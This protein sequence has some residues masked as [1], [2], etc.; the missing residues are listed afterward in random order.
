MLRRDFL[1]ASAL[2]AWA[3]LAFADEPSPPRIKV[4]QIG[5]GHGH[6]SGKFST[7]RKLSDQFEVVGIVE[8]DRERRARAER[9]KAYVGVRWL[10]EAELLATPGLKAVAIETEVRNLVPT[11]RRCVDAGLHVHLDKPAG[12]SLAQF[13][14]LLDA[15]RMKKVVVQ[16]G[17]MFRYNPA[18]RFLYQAVREGWLGQVFEVHAVMSK[19]IGPAERRGLAEYPGG[20]MFELGCHLIDS[21]TTVMGRPDRI[22]PFSRTTHPERDSLADNQLAVFEYPGA[23][24]TIRSSMLEPFGGERRHFTVCGEEGT[25]AIAPL[26]PP[27]LRL[28]LLTPRDGY[29]RGWQDVTLPKPGGRYDEEFRALAKI[30]GG[31]LAPEW[32]PEHDLLVQESVLRASGVPAA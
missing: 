1:A 30:I 6:A 13:R 22:A 4:G 19:Q 16:M 11:A 2:A 20:S 8:P 9:E 18:F 24:A 21:L 15:A 14:A 10:E 17:Y 23:T 28:A 31:E 27:A 12:E 29:K 7:M 32:T 3:P 26:E 5:T 25:I